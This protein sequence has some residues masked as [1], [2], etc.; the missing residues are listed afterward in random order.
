MQ[1]GLDVQVNQLP[2]IW[3]LETQAQPR[4]RVTR[5]DQIAADATNFHPS[6]RS[7]SVRE[8]GMT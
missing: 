1:I 7:M 3:V 6:N 4:R 2:V 8:C 5:R